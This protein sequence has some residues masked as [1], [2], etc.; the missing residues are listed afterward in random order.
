MTPCE[1]TF[2]AAVSLEQ[3]NVRGSLKKYFEVW[4]NCDNV[5]IVHRAYVNA[6][7]LANTYNSPAY[8]PNRCDLYGQG[9][10]TVD[11]F[12]SHIQWLLDL[13]NERRAALGI[14]T[15][16][17]A[18]EAAI[19]S[20]AKAIDKRGFRPA[21]C[22]EED[23]NY[24]QL[25]EYLKTYDAQYLTRESIDV[26]IKLLLQCRDDRWAPRTWDQWKA[27]MASHPVECSEHWRELQYKL[28]S[29]IETVN[30]KNLSTSQKLSYKDKLTFLNKVL[31]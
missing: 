10:I 13:S 25:F 24:L 21:G 11:F 28:E 29:W 18:T 27:D 6:C 20:L 3:Y 16:Q 1:E 9:I 7:K 17:R 19:L 23:L 30:Y 4:Q 2:A 15:H 22:S 5:T 12:L 26:W 14:D 31:N 8:F